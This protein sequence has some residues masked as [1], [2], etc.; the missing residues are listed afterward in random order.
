[1]KGKG[2][3]ETYF[4]E[5][6]D[7]GDSSLVVERL[8]VFNPSNKQARP[9]SYSSPDCGPSI[10]KWKQST[11]EDD[12]T[13]S[14]TSSVSLYPISFISRTRISS[15]LSAPLAVAHEES[16]REEDPHQDFRKMSVP[17]IMENLEIDSGGFGPPDAILLVD[18]MLSVLMQYRRVLQKT[19]LQIFTARDGLEGLFLMQQQMFVVVFMDLHMP[20]MSGSECIFKFRK[21]ENVNRIQKQRVV[22]LTGKEKLSEEEK[23]QLFAKGFDSIESKMNSKA[24]ILN[25]V[26]N[27][28]I[29]GAEIL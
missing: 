27:V 28:M 3:Q 6:V 7:I 5:D 29:D 14:S 26:T 16:E 20:K 12:D 25:S 17:F 2:M 22:A 11:V 18:D 10:E 15:A 13:A 24:A 1:V 23:S 4:L 9:R 8:S 21:W 19:G